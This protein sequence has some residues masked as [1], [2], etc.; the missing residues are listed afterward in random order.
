MAHAG[1]RPLIEISQT[2]FEQLCA[3]QCTEKEICAW[4][5]ITDKTLTR[6]CKKTYRQSFSEVFSQ[7]RKK[8]LISLR[9]SQFQLAET[10]PTM[11]IWLGKQYLKQ[12]DKQETRTEVVC[13]GLFEAIQN[14]SDNLTRSPDIEE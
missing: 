8:G 5:G 1:G 2:Q 3:M 9:R 7:K 10:N 11:A 14:I 13:N 6:W 4:F 12:T